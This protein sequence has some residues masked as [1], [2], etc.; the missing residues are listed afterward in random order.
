MKDDKITFDSFGLV[1][2]VQEDGWIEG[3]DSA[4]F[5]GH[6]IYLSG[7][8]LD[9][10]RYFELGRTG[11]FVRHPDPGSTFNAFGAYYNHAWDGVI[12]RD[13]LTG[14]LLGL[15]A[16][17][18]KAAILRV[19]IHSLAWLGLFT[20]NTRINGQDPALSKWKWPDFM[21]PNIWQMI[22]RGLIKPS[23]GYIKK[24]VMNLF[25]L[26]FQ[27][28]LVLLDLHIFIDT[29]FINKTEK[30]DV[31]NYM[32]RLFV[33]NEIAPTIISRI[34]WF[35]L[36]KEHIKGRLKA[37]WCGWRQNCGM[38]ELFEQKIEELS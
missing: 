24:K 16:R 6:Y 28:I 33:S 11:A 4:C 2:Q 12:S 38:Y 37:Y 1:G 3:G 22:I 31:I 18:D 20:Y 10:A 26:C 30:D 29:F 35:L 21:G 36:D 19:A 34:S 13:Q 17:N 15:I 14:I 25:T 9:Y 8:D 7:A 23:G 5:T 32:G 27:P